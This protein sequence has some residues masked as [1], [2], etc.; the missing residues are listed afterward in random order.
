MQSKP[1]KSKP[2]VIKDFIKLEPE[3]QLQVLAFYNL[4]DVDELAKKL[5]SYTEEAEELQKKVQSY[6]DPK[7]G[8][9][10]FALPYETEDRFYMVRVDDFINTQVDGGQDN[11]D[12]DDLLKNIEE[13]KVSNE[14]QETDDEEEEKYDTP[15]D[16]EDDEDEDGE[17]SEE[18]DDEEDDKE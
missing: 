14:E 15:E 17:I 4:A 6:T 5:Q 16:L 10:R 12:D 11:D 9:E 8:Q 1:S 2:R 7:T 13:V 18:E 3:L